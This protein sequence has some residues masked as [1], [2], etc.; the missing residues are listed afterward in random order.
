MK[1]KDNFPKG[2][3]AFSSAKTIFPQTLMEQKEK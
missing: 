3:D 1:E 2:D